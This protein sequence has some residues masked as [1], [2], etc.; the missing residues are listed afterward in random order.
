MFLTKRTFV[1]KNLTAL[2]EKLISSGKSKIARAP[3]HLIGITYFSRS[4]LT[5]ISCV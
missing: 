3:I 2:V 5:I 1:F 4:E